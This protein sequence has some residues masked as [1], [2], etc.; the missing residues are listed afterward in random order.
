MGF[1]Q[2]NT[3][4]LRRNN[5]FFCDPSPNDRSSDHLNNSISLASWQPS[6]LVL[7]AKLLE[8]TVGVWSQVY[9]SYMR[10]AQKLEVG[11]GIT[12]FVNALVHCSLSVA[13][14][15]MKEITGEIT[16]IAPVNDVV[17]SVIFYLLPEFLIAVG[18]YAHAVRR[19]GVGFFVVL[20]LGIL[21][22]VFYCWL[23]ITGIAFM[24]PL[25]RM[26]IY[27]GLSPALFAA[28]CMGC[29]IVYESSRPKGRG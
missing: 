6:I 18:S 15:L 24:G 14:R 26:R 20:V 11:F 21:L 22:I 28:L 12:T 27:F 19:S 3:D 25:S 1:P 29:G 16:G 4:D 9:K 8:G 17:V 5:Y 10:T 7:F 23:L 13:P 2:C